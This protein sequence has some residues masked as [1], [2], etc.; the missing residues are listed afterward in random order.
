MLNCQE[1][2][3]HYFL[4]K[5]AKFNAG[6]KAARTECIF[7]GFVRAASP[8]NLV[9]QFYGRPSCFPSSLGG[10]KR[11]AR[12]CLYLSIRRSRSLCNPA[13]I[14]FAR[15]TCCF[16]KSLAV[17]SPVSFFCSSESSFSA[18]LSFSDIL[19]STTEAGKGLGRLGPPFPKLG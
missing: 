12:R 6:Y 13:R 3:V 9:G 2:T 11:S 17:Y 10:G 8:C 19:E 7:S 1:E 4:G 5:A 15:S 14:F 16:N 18:S